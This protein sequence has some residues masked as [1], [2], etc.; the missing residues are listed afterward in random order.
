MA[1]IVIFMIITKSSEWKE[2]LVA[3]AVHGVL[4][5]LHSPDSRIIIMTIVMITKCVM[6]FIIKMFLKKN[7]VMP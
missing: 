5:L 1:P 6:V 3:A 4:T 7:G 2:R